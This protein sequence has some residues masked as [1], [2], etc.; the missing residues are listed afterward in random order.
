MTVNPAGF[1]GRFTRSVVI[2]SNDLNIR[3][4]RLILTGVAEEAT[5]RNS[6][7]DSPES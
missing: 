2:V 1:S 5:P 3:H 4:K 7:K 6:A